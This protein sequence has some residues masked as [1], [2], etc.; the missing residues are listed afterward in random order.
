[1]LMLNWRKNDEELLVIVIFM[2]VFYE[3]WLKRGYLKLFSVGV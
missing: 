1:M 3:C 2:W